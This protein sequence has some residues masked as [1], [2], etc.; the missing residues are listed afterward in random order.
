M[1]DSRPG[2]PHQGPHP[3]PLAETLDPL[4][5]HSC[6]GFGSS[7]LPVL[8]T[9]CEEVE[10]QPEEPGET[11]VEEQLDGIGDVSEHLTPYFE[12]RM[13]RNRS[14]IAEREGPDSRENPQALEYLGGVRSPG[15]GPL[16]FLGLNGQGHGRRV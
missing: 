7:L 12:V 9:L 6:S 4:T 15:S 16:L 3:Q 8:G 5:P 2:I 11:H 13:I 14:E 10:S 1:H